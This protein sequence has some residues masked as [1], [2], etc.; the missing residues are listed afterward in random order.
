MVYATAWLSAAG[1]KISTLS[2]RKCCKI[3]FFG[4]KYNCCRMA[5]VVDV[6]VFIIRLRKIRCSFIQSLLFTNWWLVAGIH[7]SLLRFTVDLIDW[8][9]PQCF[10]TVFIFP[11]R[12]KNNFIL[13]SSLFWRLLWGFCICLV[14]IIIL[15]DLTVML[16][17]ILDQNLNTI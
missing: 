5:I 15:K 1:C 4:M 12:D 13:C 6:Y 2:Q 16:Y 9:I 10:Y 8:L 14:T 7:R 11:Y 3:H 17:S